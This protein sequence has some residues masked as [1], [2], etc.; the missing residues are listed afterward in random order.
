MPIAV[1]ARFWPATSASL[2]PSARVERT[3]EPS[4]RYALDRRVADGSMFDSG[5]SAIDAGRRRRDAAAACSG[6]ARRSRRR[7]RCDTRR[8]RARS[9]A[10]R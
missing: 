10:D 8:R 5:R 4:P 6:R 7:S 1:T 2:T 3:G 9:R